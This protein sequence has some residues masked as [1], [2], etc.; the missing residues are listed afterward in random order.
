MAYHITYIS[1]AAAR[2]TRRLGR[3]PLLTD[4]GMQKQESLQKVAESQ[5]NVAIQKRESLQNDADTVKLKTHDMLQ[6]LC[7]IISTL[8]SK[9]AIFGLPSGA[10]EAREAKAYLPRKQRH[11]FFE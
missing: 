8:K 11:I 6:A 4:T 2:R 9:S 7:F 5:F 3:G 10:T 1:P